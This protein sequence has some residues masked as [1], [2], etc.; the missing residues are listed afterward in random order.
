A[1]HVVARRRAT[2]RV[3]QAGDVA[4]LL[5]G[6]EQRVAVGLK[7]LGDAAGIAGRAQ[8]V[9]EQADS[10]E[11]RRGGP[12]PGGRLGAVEPDEQRA[13]GEALEIGGHRWGPGRCSSREAR[14]WYRSER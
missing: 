1:E 12:D 4:T 6:G 7:D 9:A 3:V 2:G 14:N 11:S 10:A 13:R 8:V 5:V